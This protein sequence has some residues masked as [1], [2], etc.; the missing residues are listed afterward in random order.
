MAYLSKLDVLFGQLGHSMP[1]FWVISLA[2]RIW[3]T[4]RIDC[5]LLVPQLRICR[6][7]A[8]AA[9]VR[10]TSI[11]LCATV[12][13]PAEQDVLRTEAGAQNVDLLSSCVRSNKSSVFCPDCSD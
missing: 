12:W 13:S 8:T 6:V 1:I 4:S 5:R 10:A 7:N 3:R 2:D 11:Q 9:L